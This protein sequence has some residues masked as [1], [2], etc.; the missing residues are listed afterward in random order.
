MIPLCHDQGVA[1]IPWRPLARGLF[2][3]PRSC[4]PPG[5]P[6]SLRSQADDIIAKYDSHESDARVRDALTRVAERKDASHAGI[7][8]AWLLMQGVAA[9]IVGITRERDL[10]ALQAALAIGL[11]A[12]D[13]N[14]LSE[15]HEPHPVAGFG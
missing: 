3:R 11:D 15:F 13:M 8:L 6:P 9:P 14:D 10:D 12:T 5:P 7:A 1:V 2:A 4:S